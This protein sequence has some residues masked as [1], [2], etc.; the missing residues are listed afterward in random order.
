MAT[1]VKFQRGS[2]RNDG[3][4][5]SFGSRL[6]AFLLGHVEVVDVSSVMFAGTIGR[7]F[8]MIDMADIAHHN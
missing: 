7:H 2:E 3:G 1:A 4:D 5:V 6:G 8:S